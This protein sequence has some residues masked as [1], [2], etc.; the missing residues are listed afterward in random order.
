M[1]PKAQTWL[2]LIVL[3]LAVGL[4]QTQEPVPP[5]L[6]TPE[7]PKADPEPPAPGPEVVAAK[8]NG[9]P[10]PELS[11]YR[12]LRRVPPLMRDKARKEILSFLIDNLVVEQY[13]T[14][15]KVQ[16]DP[17]EIDER[18]DQIKAEAIKDK[19]VFADLLKRLHIT[20]A[21]L[22]RELT[23]AL[24]WDKFVL[25][26]GTDKV[27]RDM[28]DANPAMFDGSLMRARHILLPADEGK[29]EETKAKIVA[30][31]KNIEDQAAKE[32]AQLPA[33]TDKFKR[34]LERSKAL[35]K[36]FAEAAA[37]HSTCGSSSEGGDVGRFKRTGKMVEPFARAAFALKPYQMSDPVS[38]EFGVH[39]ILAVDYQP[40]KQTKFEEVKGIVQEVY[41]ERLREAVLTAYKTRSKIEIMKK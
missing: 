38:T 31:R 32:I 39:L 36:A 16:V 29:A 13:L 24:R 4:A 19:I 25:Q 22:R 21:D 30:L 2:P 28:F 27:L 35:E 40:G 8:V 26:Q 18:V 6:P 11:V 33:E 5:P 23:G 12:G 34:E 3:G 20:E 1:L 15:L 10:I 37:K 14:Q 9:Q 17:K 41:A 7:V